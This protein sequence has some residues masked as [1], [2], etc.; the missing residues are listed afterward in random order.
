M[1]ADVIDAYLTRQRS[2]GMRFDSAGQLLRRFGRAIGARPIQEVT[3]EAVLDFLNGRGALTATWTLKHKVLTGLYRFAVSRGYVDSSPLPTTLPKLPPQQTPYVYSNDELRRLL[4]ATTILCAGHSRHVP[5]M[6]RT[7]LLLLYGTGMRIGEAL[8]LT[9]QDVDLVER[10]ITVHGTKFFKNSSGSDR[11]QAC[12]RTGGARRAPRLVARVAHKSS[13]TVRVAR[14]SRMEL[15]ASDR[16]VPARA[17][18]CWRH[19]P[20]RRTTPAALARPSSHRGRA[21]R[22]R[23]VSR[24]PGRPET[25]SATR[26]LPRSP[27]YPIDPALPPNDARALAGGQPAFRRLRAGGRS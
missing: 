10:V 1:L 6:Y 19:L 25:A 12:R 9:L 14:R 18:S 5:A 21:P 11:T 23:M 26:H 20:H 16:D 24:R 4:E 15:S 27:R 2:L 3:P 22:R 7:L 8:R 17:T 13:A